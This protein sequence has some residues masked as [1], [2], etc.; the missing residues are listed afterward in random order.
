MY[1]EYTYRPL[2]ESE[3]DRSGRGSGW[4]PQSDGDTPRYGGISEED[5]PPREVYGFE[6]SP[7]LHQ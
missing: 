7:P 6:P 2:D 1:G 5:L 3:S 4:R